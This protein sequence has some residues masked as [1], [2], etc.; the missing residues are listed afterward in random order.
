MVVGSNSV[1]GARGK[2]RSNS[3]DGCAMCHNSRRSPSSQSLSTLSTLSCLFGVSNEVLAFNE[4]PFRVI[5]QLLATFWR[6][7]EERAPECR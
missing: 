4:F 3:A 1:D 7:P 2:W 5:E 6:K